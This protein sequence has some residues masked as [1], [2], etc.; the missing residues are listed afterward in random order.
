MAAFAVA[1]APAAVGFDDIAART[2]RTRAAI[3]RGANP[4]LFDLLALL[5]SAPKLSTLN[6]PVRTPSTSVIFEQASYHVRVQLSL[7]R[8]AEACIM[9]A[10]VDDIDF[11][12]FPCYNLTT[13]SCTPCETTCSLLFSLLP[14]TG[15]SPLLPPINCRNSSR[16]VKPSL[17]SLTDASPLSLTP[18]SEQPLRQPIFLSTIC[19]H[20]R[21]QQPIL[22]PPPFIPPNTLHVPTS[23]ASDSAAG[24]DRLL[25]LFPPVVVPVADSN[26][27]PVVEQPLLLG[28][29]SATAPE[30]ARLMTAR[31]WTRVAAQAP[32]SS[33]SASSRRSKSAKKTKKIEDL[34]HTPITTKP[35]PTSR[36]KVKEIASLCGLSSSSV[37]SDA[38]LVSADTNYV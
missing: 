20:M 27:V 15:A 28:S 4:D 22:A 2:G 5:A 13:N 10:Q 32:S 6:Y 25:Q 14:P 3:R 30:S 19:K 11:P 37:L 9:V 7:R 31:A 12:S 16:K 35:Q 33:G 18:L 17:A 29:T 26:L 8:S 24:N 1:V 38:S 21:A 23:N 34:L 36:K